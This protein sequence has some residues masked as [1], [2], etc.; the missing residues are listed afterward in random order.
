MP[1]ELFP[2]S[3]DFTVAI[4]KIPHISK[5]FSAMLLNLSFSMLKQEK[6]ERLKG[7]LRATLR[8]NLKVKRTDALMMTRFFSKATFSCTFNS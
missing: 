8:T 1:K 6:P 2:D 7:D 5:H 3:T 4:F